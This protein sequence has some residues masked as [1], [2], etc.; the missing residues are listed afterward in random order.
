VGHKE[1][2]PGNWRRVVLIIALSAVCRVLASIVIRLALAETFCVNCGV[3]TL[4][5]PTTNLDYDNKN[6]L[7]EA[8]ARL[9]CERGNRQRNFQ[10]VVITHDEDFVHMVRHTPRTTTEQPM[11]PV[12]CYVLTQARRLVM[13]VVRR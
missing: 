7:A 13:C 9:I 1:S 10:L 3:M 12:D 6:G 2:L 11:I 8:L 5:E 4:D